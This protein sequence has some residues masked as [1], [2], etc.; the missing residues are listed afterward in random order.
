[1]SPSS[2]DKWIV[3]CAGWTP[4][5][6]RLDAPANRT[7]AFWVIDR[8]EPISAWKGV[9]M[10]AEHLNF[11]L[12]RRDVLTGMAKLGAAGVVAA[13]GGATALAGAAGAT[14][15]DHDHDNEMLPNGSTLEKSVD[16]DDTF[17]VAGAFS[18]AWA[19]ATTARYGKDDQL[20]SLNHV[21]PAKTAKALRML[22][23]GKEVVT[24]RLG[25]LMVNDMPGFGTFPPRKYSQR[26]TALGYTPK[27]PS[28]WFSTTTRGNAGEDEWRAADR[29]NGPLG[30]FQGPT[31]F[32]TTELSV[33]EERFL[34]GGTYQLATQ[35]DTFNHVGVRDVFYNG[36]NAK[37]FAT[38]TGTTKLGMET[39]PPFVTR[40]V[41]L[42][43]L[44]LK[45]SQGATSAIQT[46]NGN[47]MLTNSYRI[48]VEDIQDAMKRAKLKKIGPGDVVCFRT[49]WHRLA[50]DPTTYKQYLTT[51]PGI[52]IREAK[53]LADHQPALVA[54]D[55][56]ALELLPGKP[57]SDPG[58]LFIVH[59]E[60]LVKHGIRIGEG[61]IVTDLAEDGAFEFVYM[62]SPQYAKGATAG[63]T[64][65]VG[66][67]AK[68]KG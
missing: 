56:W 20:G 63:N 45:I 57:V 24:Y 35:F 46:V 53:W 51:E 1:M 28:K 7:A 16:Y 14:E 37:D 6:H 30:Y 54:A 5:G 11:H 19:A 17:S 26:L 39:V 41:I 58:Q 15:A 21:T 64:A 12:N 59:Q 3:Q 38:P 62:Y 23:K 68:R 33:H 8:A 27:D 40:G 2:G 13:A 55:S 44:D 47:K 50:D 32:G 48:T 43:I 42:D 25:H 4:V 65:P 18:G 67:A 31:G 9:R 34:E 60:L 49:G 10:R 29:A 52:Y 22:D 66:L 61:V 36:F